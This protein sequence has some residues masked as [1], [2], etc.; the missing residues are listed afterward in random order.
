MYR[1]LSSLSATA[2]SFSIL[3]FRYWQAQHHD[4]EGKDT[5]QLNSSV[6]TS[7]LIVTGILPL[8]SCAIVC[9]DHTGSKS[10]IDYQGI[11]SDILQ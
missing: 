6:V 10:Y 9:Q 7:I 4:V 5:Q 11:D 2:L 3:L 1:S 8:V